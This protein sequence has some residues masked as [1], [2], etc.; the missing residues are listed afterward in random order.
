MD[1]SKEQIHEFKKQVLNQINSTFPEDKKQSAIEQINSMNDEQFIEF[2]KQNKLINSDGNASSENPQNQCIF[3]SIV[4]N[5]IPSTKIGENEKAIAILELNP[6]SKGHALII[7]KNHLSSQ[8]SLEKETYD[9]SKQIIE[10]LE[11][12]FSPK[13]VRVIPANIMGHQILNLLPIYSNETMNS[14][15]QQK[16]P[17]ELQD[18]KNEIEK[19]NEIK[20]EE[21][22]TPEKELKTVQE[23]NSK[24]VWLPKRIP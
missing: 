15:K 2:L 19:I 14:P 13:E 1:I 16:T 9:L 3:C 5:E 11:K 23:I 6:I 22:Q 7:P 24:S 17:E 18:L 12:T 4:F 20:T 8:E 10:K 21:K